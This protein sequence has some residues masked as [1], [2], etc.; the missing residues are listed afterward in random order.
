MEPQLIGPTLAQFL[1]IAIFLGAVIKA[2]AG[3][4][5]CMVFSGDI[6]GKDTNIDGVFSFEEYSALHSE[7][8]RW[9][10]KALD[11]DNDGSNSLSDWE[12]FLK[13]HGV[14]KGSLIL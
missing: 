14:G 9:G 2:H 10:F 11:T 1:A 5:G 3:N 12:T 7:K 6:F 4:H 13:V 8:P